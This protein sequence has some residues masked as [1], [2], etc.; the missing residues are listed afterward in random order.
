[1][2]PCCPMRAHHRHEA[3]PSLADVVRA[4]LLGRTLEAR[5]EGA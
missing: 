4:W 1:M 3:A 5:T 2:T